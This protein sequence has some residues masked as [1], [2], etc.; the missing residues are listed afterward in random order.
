MS[1][2]GYVVVEY[3]Q[4]SGR[5]T[6]V[7]GAQLLELLDDRASAEV[8]AAGYRAVTVAVDRRERYVVYEL[9]RVEDPS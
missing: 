9:V 8:D 3:N 7:F 5:P 2:V 4:A 6:V 1:V